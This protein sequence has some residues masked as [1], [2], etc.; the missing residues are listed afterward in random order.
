MENQQESLQHKLVLEGIDISLLMKYKVISNVLSDTN[1]SEFIKSS[2]LLSEQEMCDTF[3]L[4]YVKVKEIR[5]KIYNEYSKVL[6]EGFK[7]IPQYNMYAVN[8][9]GIVINKRSRSIMSNY[10]NKHSDGYIRYNIS[11]TVNGVR[12][13]H[14]TAHKAV[15]LTFIPNQENKLEVNHID[16]N[17]SNNIVSNLEWTTLQENMK[18]K[19][20]NNLCS[21]VTGERNVNSKL[22]EEAVKQIR[23]FSTE[24]GATAKFLSVKFGVALS[25]VSRVIRNESWK[26]VL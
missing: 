7:S 2:A 8:G 17:K 3:N 9:E 4:S 25:T 23:Y 5:K 22:T 12:K 13:K 1:L 16:G 10:Q 14:I 11:A 6:P 19:A 21:P 20:E 24:F 26:H 18:H 15:A